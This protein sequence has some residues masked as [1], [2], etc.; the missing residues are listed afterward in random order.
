M[1]VMT[2]STLLPKFNGTW[3]FSRRIR[4][5]LSLV[6][7]VALLGSA[8]GVWSLQRVASE[9]NRMVDDAMATERLAVDLYRH[10]ALNVARS[11]AFALSSEPQVGDVLTPEINQTSIAVDELLRQLGSRLTSPDDQLMLG[12]MLQANRE[13]LRARQELTL[14]RDGGLT[15]NIERVYANRFTPTAQALLEAVARLRD[16]RQARIDASVL[17]I[18][19]LSLSAQWGLILFGC[20]ALLLGG[21]LSAW[22]VRAITQ[23][24]HQAVDAA[25]RVAALDLSDPIEGHDRDE[26]GRLLA[27]LSRMQSSLHTL[28]S[29]VQGASHGVAE[30]A[31][32]IA[33]GNLDFSSRTELAASF[34]QQTAAAVEQIAATLHQSLAAAS[35]GE[36][37]ARSAAVEATAGRKAMTEVMQTMSDISQSSHQIAEITAVI[38]GIAFQTNILA[39]NAAVEAARAGE[40]GRGF[41]VVAAEVRALANRSAVA[42]REI[43]SLIGVS[44]DKAKL[45]TLNVRQARDT[46]SAIDDAVARVV[47]VIGDISIGTREQSASMASIN[48]ALS[49]LDQMT[50][51]NA[52]VVEESAAAAQSLQA[53]AGDLR[54]MAGQFR[55]PSLALR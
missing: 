1:R 47:Q 41:A 9:T 28:V 48:T 8:L 44:V 35:R 11:K 32:Q 18:S 27:A 53:Q 34:L 17:E 30:G 16:S 37:L 6:L 42:A 22:L 25:D 31:T 14:A 29:E 2:M 24:I 5:V 43:R 36:A 23:P 39:L 46:M 49:R 15:A 7:A 26:G 52:A 38:D 21:L 45:G 3:S 50:Q 40:H 10:L 13:F 20:G 54:D 33:T 19:D 4:V 55:L 12:H 51:Q